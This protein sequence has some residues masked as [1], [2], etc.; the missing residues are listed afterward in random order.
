MPGNDL[1]DFA[2]ILPGWEKASHWERFRAVD[3]CKTV[4]KIPLLF[5]C[6]KDRDSDIR[7]HVA[8][9]LHELGNEVCNYLDLPEFVAVLNS[10][11]DEIRAA[12]L[13]AMS[14]PSVQL[15][16]QAIQI[17]IVAVADPG[18]QTQSAARTLLALAC[19]LDGMEPLLLAL[20][21]RRR[22]P[23]TSHWSGELIDQAFADF[24]EAIERCRSDQSLLPMLQ[25][26]EAVT[27]R[28]AAA[29]VGALHGEIDAPALKVAAGDPDHTTCRAAHSI[30][31]KIDPLGHYLEVQNEPNSIIRAQAIRMLPATVVTEDLVD[32]LVKGTR[33]DSPVMRETC[34]RTLGKNPGLARHYGAE[35][36]LRL[37]DDSVGIRYA[38]IE[39]L[40]NWFPETQGALTWLSRGIDEPLGPEDAG[41][42]WNALAAESSADLVA[43]LNRLLA[44]TDEYLRFFGVEAGLTAPN[45]PPDLRTRLAELH[46]AIWK[47]R[48]ENWRVRGDPD[49]GPLFPK[50]THS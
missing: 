30:L 45:L 50:T 2:L 7:D 15:N 41:A 35:L 42:V 25:P 20:E 43:A 34:L 27:R 22:V 9:A 37:G 14:Y 24:K 12:A 47:Q 6:L 11:D 40:R 44:S 21:E 16:T 23:Q 4:D 18:V 8:Y 17:G 5:R 33:D 3:R 46:H 13:H 39:L 36:V 29:V 1:S 19:S 10:P 38:F 28:R 31:S 49:T 48:M 32:V 26:S